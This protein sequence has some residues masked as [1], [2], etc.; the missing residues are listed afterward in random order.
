MQQ[1]RIS[2]IPFVN[3]VIGFIGK[4]YD[5]HMEDNLDSHTIKECIMLY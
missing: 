2:V 1:M 3:G 4:G 5:R